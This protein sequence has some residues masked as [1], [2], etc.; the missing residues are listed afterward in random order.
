MLFEH[1]RSFRSLTSDVAASKRQ[2]HWIYTVLVSGYGSLSGPSGSIVTNSSSSDDALTIGGGTN[3][4]S[5]FSRIIN[6]EDMARQA[7][8]RSYYA[9]EAVFLYS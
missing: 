2:Q 4:A 5:V 1:L 9:R 8:Y 6:D 7:R 3:I